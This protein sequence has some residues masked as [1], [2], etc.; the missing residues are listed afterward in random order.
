MSLCDSNSLAVKA[1]IYANLC[2]T[3]V[4]FLLSRRRRREEAAR[5]RLLSGEARIGGHLRGPRSRALHK[6]R[7]LR[8]GH[9]ARTGAHAWTL[10]KPL[11]RATRNPVLWKT[12][13]PDVLQLRSV[14]YTRNYHSRQPTSYLKYK[15]CP[16]NPNACRCCLLV[17]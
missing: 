6:R 14:L 5:V 11:T 10:R 8:T 17:S 4:V 12:A 7:S 1:H 16:M 9:R 2:H 15:Y 3:T 13:R